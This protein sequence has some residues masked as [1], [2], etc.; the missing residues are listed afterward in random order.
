MYITLQTLFK[1]GDKVKCKYHKE[2]FEGIIEGID[3]R[4]YKNKNY[5]VKYFIPYNNH[6]YVLSEK[7]I[8]S[9]NNRP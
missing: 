5:S 8:T 3:I 9:T 7:D 6:H 4:I 2:K 1:I